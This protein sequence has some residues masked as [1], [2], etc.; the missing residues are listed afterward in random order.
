[1]SSQKQVSTQGEDFS[2]DIKE[3]H[4]EVKAQ[5]QKSSKKY[6]KHADQKRRHLEFEVGDLK[7]DNLK[8]ERLSKC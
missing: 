3:I 6:K 7:C 2:I 1:M 4:D 5:L 8:K